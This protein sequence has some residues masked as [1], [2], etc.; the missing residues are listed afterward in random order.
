[1]KVLSRWQLTFDPDGDT[2]KVL[3][4]FGDLLDDELDWKLGRTVEVVPLAAAAAPFIRPAGNNVYALEFTVY[5]VSDT[6]EL[7]RKAVMDILRTTDD[8]GKAP[9]RL[10]I[11][12]ESGPVTSYYYQ[13]ANAAV[14]DFGAKRDLDSSRP[15]H[16]RRYSI[17]ATKLTKTTV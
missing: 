1:M 2:P 5:K 13:F 7:A 9:L 10:E 15:R 3:L 6:D 16:G 14:R 4:A 12:T 17:L 8:L 11:S